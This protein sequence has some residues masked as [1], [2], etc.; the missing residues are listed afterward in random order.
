[1]SQELKWLPAAKL[2]G[3]RLPVT[4]LSLIAVICSSKHVENLAICFSVAFH[5]IQDEGR[6]K[7]R[8]LQNLPI[9]ANFIALPL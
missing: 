8:R 2:A 5:Y 7:A 6:A 4:S 3:R 1:M 9:M